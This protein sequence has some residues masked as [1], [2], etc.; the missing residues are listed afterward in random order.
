MENKK[1]NKRAMRVKLIF[2]PTAGPKGESPLQLMDITKEMQAWNLI[3]ETF[4]IEPDC[5]LDKVVDEAIAHGIKLIAVC[6]G[7]G[8]V[9]SVA[10]ALLGKPAILGIIPGGTANN[11]ALSLNIPKDI[12]SAIAILREGHAAKIDIGMA[13]IGKVVTPLIEVCSVGLFSTLY[14]SADDIQHGD[15]GKV[16]DFV[17][18]VFA[19]PPSE[20]HFTLDNKKEVQ[21]FGHI[22]LIT[23]MPYIGPNLQ[24]GDLDSCQ[25][26]LLDVLFFA[27]L[28]KLDILSSIVRG[29]GLDTA[30][31]PR[32]QRYKA[33]HIR[34]ET[35]PPMPILIDNMQIGEGS[36]EIEVKRHALTVMTGTKTDKP[37]KGIPSIEK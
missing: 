15:L 16:G 23:N 19:T 25:D 18:K 27:D 32:I 5:D 8:T 10:R 14:A 29:I 4:L 31:D 21:K 20:I 2:N 17:T 12:P 26:G 36:V 13:T 33:R 7:D 24:V 34:I 9:E 3:P 22:V 37:L 35:V 1:T 11:V 6:G 28:N 30:A